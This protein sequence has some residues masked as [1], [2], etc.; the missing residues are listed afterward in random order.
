MLGC[1][2]HNGCTMRPVM[3]YFV[4]CD[5]IMERVLLLLLT[6]FRCT[7]FPLLSTVRSSRKYPHRPPGRDFSKIPTPIVWKFQLSFIH[8]HFFKFVGL[9]EPPTPAPSLPPGNSNPFWKGSMDISLELHIVLTEVDK[10]LT[11]VSCETHVLFEASHLA[12]EIIKKGNQSRNYSKQTYIKSI[13]NDI[14]VLCWHLSTRKCDAT[15]HSGFILHYKSRRHKGLYKIDTRQCFTGK[16]TTH[17]VHKKLH[18]GL[19]FSMSSLVRI[20][21]ISLISSGLAH[22]VDA[23]LRN[24]N[25]LTLDFLLF[26][27][28]LKSSG[29]K[30]LQN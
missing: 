15:W 8:E 9:T 14:H 28:I 29:C 26:L 4:L 30:T 3:C 12:K 16:Y 7:V 25:G 20:S 6:K 24:K 23:Q 18:P 11:C 2:V 21:M 19:V 17:K 22:D 27:I 10:N 13:F 5:W 1:K